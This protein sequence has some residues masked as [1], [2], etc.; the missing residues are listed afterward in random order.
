M[1]ALYYFSFFS[2][3]MKKCKKRSFIKRIVYESHSERSQY[4]WFVSK[5]KENTCPWPWLCL[6]KEGY[7]DHIYL[8]RVTYTQLTFIT[9]IMVCL[10]KTHLFQTDLVEI[11]MK[12]IIWLDLVL[13]QW[14]Y[15][16]N[17][18]IVDGIGNLSSNLKISPHCKTV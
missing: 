16:R 9:F 4:L 14:Y 17:A 6:L 2:Y 13:T 11:I 1:I 12:V 18:L 7:P 10:E 8:K 15:H 3:F 5:T